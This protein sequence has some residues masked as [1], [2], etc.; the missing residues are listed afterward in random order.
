MSGVYSLDDV[1]YDLAAAI[2]SYAYYLARGPDDAE[3]D[4]E[5]SVRSLVEAAGR[6]APLLRRALFMNEIHKVP[7]GPLTPYRA[8]LLITEAEQSPLAL[9]EPPTYPMPDGSGAA[10]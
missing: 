9:E 7:G 6:S 1:P 5:E 8:E 3:R 4:Q 10:E 2:A